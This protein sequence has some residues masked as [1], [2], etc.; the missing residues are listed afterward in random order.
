MHIF[1]P[2]FLRTTIPLPMTI[3]ENGPRIFVICPGR[4]NP[5]EFHI[6]DIFK[7]YVLFTDYLLIEDDN[8]I[9][10]GLIAILDLTNVT[11]EHFSQ[12]KPEFVKKMTFLCQHSS[13]VRPKGF[14]YINTPDG[15]EF[16][17]NM[18]KSFMSEEYK[19][20]VSYIKLR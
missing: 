16:V 1:Y 12:F 14:H 9:V 8:F 20:L 19:R 11:P 18:F 7:M 2:L 17:F 4:Y 6:V 13:P 3:E 15:F 5:K 10:G